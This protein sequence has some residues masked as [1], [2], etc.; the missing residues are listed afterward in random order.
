MCSELYERTMYC[1]N[2]YYTPKQWI[3]ENT[4]SSVYFSE[5]LKFLFL[6][7]YHLEWEKYDWSLPRLEKIKRKKAVLFLCSIW[8]S[9]T[10]KWYFKKMA[11]LFLLFQLKLLVAV[12]HLCVQMCLR[13]VW[14]QQFLP[15]SAVWHLDTFISFHYVSGYS[16]QLL[17][18]KMLP[19]YSLIT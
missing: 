12:Y 5:F 8:C 15:H 3:C 2:R 1:P 14:E 7:R 16:H 13:T 18:G 4:F 17:G 19:L 11:S 10:F 9:K 6:S